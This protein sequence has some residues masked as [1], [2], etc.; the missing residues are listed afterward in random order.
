MEKYYLAYG[1]NLSVEQMAQRCP[2]AIYV[3]TAE[4]KNYQLLFKRG[5]SG[6][7]LTVEPK[8]G[9][10]V[11]VLVWRISE[12]DEES[13]DVYEGY[14]SLYYKTMMTVDVLPFVGSKPEAETE[15]LIYIMHEDKPFGNPTKEYYEVCLEGYRRFR[16][17]EAILAKALA[18]ST[19]A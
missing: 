17:D 3:G 8:A 4:L 5:Q 14:P 11:P 18:D 15:A 9:S 10:V 1:S 12:R 16:F 7:Y 2:D 19:L 13:L 6:S